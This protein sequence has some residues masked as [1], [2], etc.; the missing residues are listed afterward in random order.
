MAGRGEPL[1]G[2]SAVSIGVALGDSRLG[3]SSEASRH[4]L[5]ILERWG[6]A[7]RREEERTHF[8]LFHSCKHA[9]DGAALQKNLPGPL[10]LLLAL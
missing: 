2:G 9:G 1:L 7:A 10:G 6:R 5:D 4:P 8:Q 3:F